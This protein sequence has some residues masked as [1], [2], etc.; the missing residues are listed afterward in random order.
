MSPRYAPGFGPA[1]YDRVKAVIVGLA[2]R[3]DGWF[4]AND[5]LAEALNAGATNNAGNVAQILDDLTDLE[6]LERSP[7]DPPRWRAASGE[8]A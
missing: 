3:T 5:A 7:S 6:E 1:D 8:P 2:R 4:N